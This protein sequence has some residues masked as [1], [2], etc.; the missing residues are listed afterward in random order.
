MEYADYNSGT[1]Q[2]NY[3]LYW[4]D[5]IISCSS[6]AFDE[7][8]NQ[9]RAICNCGNGDF[10]IDDDF[11]TCYYTGRFVLQEILNYEL[12]KSEHFYVERKH[13]IFQ[14]IFMPFFGANIPF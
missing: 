9:Q 6:A 2:C 10:Y 4:N 13:L 1:G 8:R 3:T 14:A 12:E 7:S 5:V 11:D